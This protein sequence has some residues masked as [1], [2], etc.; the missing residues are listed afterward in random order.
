LHLLSYVHILFT[1]TCS[2]IFSDNAAQ[3]H[4]G[5]LYSFNVSV[6]IKEHATL[7]FQNNSVTQLCGAVY[8]NDN[9]TVEIMENTRV[10]FYVKRATRGR[11]AIYFVDKSRI[12][13]T[14]HSSMLFAYNTVEHFG[15]AIHCDGDSEVTFDR[16]I[17]ATFKSNN[18]EHGGG[19]SIFQC[20]LVFAEN[21]FLWFDNN[22]A[23]GNG[24]AIHLVNNFTVAFEDT[25][26]LIFDN[27]TASHY[28]GAICGDLSHDS[29]SKLTFQS[30]FIDF[31]SNSAFVGPSVSI[32]Y[33][34]PA[35][36][37]V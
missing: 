22:A 8:S 21:S 37:L 2:I 1:G 9:V 29:H 17:S 34:H 20:S 19:V 13:I 10:I 30:H 28:G 16:N 27:N 26:K 7:T 6:K 5:V 23:A 3:Q 18:A 36:I 25:S 15:G 12:V 14:G 24:G 32:E 35:M 4:G 33:H 31:H 11:G